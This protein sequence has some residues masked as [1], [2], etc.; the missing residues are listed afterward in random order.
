MTTLTLQPPEWQT[1]QAALQREW[2]VTN[3]LGGWASGTVGGA[4]TR[5]Y[6]GSLVAALHPPVDR[7]VLVSKLDD[8]ATLDCVRYGLC[9]N[10]FEGGA[11]DPQGW[12]HL[13]GFALEDGLPHWTF[14]LGSG[15][16]E[17]R[18]FMPYGHN[19]TW[20][21]WTYTSGTGPLNLEI[22]ALCNAR[23]FHGQTQAANWQLQFQAF[24]AGVCVRVNDSAPSV[25]LVHPGAAFE[26]GPVWIKNLHYQI[27]A[28]R[29]LPD[30]EDVLKI[31][32][33]TASLTPGDTLALLVSA[34]APS[35]QAYNWREALA[36]AQQRQRQV[37]VNS[38]L[39][40]QAPGWVEQLVLAADQFIVLRTDSGL[41][42][43][44]QWRTP[45]P[46]SDQTVIAGYPWFSDWGR[47]TMI[48]LPGLTLATHRAA[49]AAGILRTFAKHL[50]QGMLPN[51]FPDSG[52]T[53]E[54]NTVDATL[55]YFHAID[56]YLEATNDE[57]LPRELFD[58]LE[59]IIA[60]HLKGTRY[61]IHGDTDGLL[62]AGEAGV[63]LTWMDAKVG[64][65]VVTPRIGK[66]VEINALWINALRVMD[67]LS[68]RLALPTRQPYAA[69][70][71]QAQA[72]FGKFWNA[73]D[74]CL[75]DVIDGPTLAQDASIRPNQLL[76]ISLPYAPLDAKSAQAKSVVAVCQRDLLTPVGLRSLAPQSAE[77]TP[78]FRGGP[79][80]RDGAY[81]QGTIW[82][83]LIGPFVEAHFKVYGDK[84]QA[85]DFLKPLEQALRMFGLGT[86]AEVY[87]A[88]PPYNPAGCFAQAW[89][90]SEALRL[91]RALSEGSVAR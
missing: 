41:P 70:A 66:P 4:N 26:A 78:L 88:T 47:D 89:S 39:P 5:R 43:V 82:G 49:E 34:E 19:A 13:S 12:T 25:W 83:W 11:I 50:S 15:T 87:E 72:S 45:D 86:L 27:E 68:R 81:H 28:G 8:W 67:N 62:Y 69:L 14:A 6:H 16:L 38:R 33:V 2:L 51:R 57:A 29:G 42:S 77:Y 35:P 30:H 76:A 36:A 9:A 73:K 84:D 65:W 10:E 48:A 74:G 44:T 85:L 71:D 22:S 24:P 61:Q 20:T 56:R 23:D 18:V 60:W 80:E 40:S 54:Y 46:Q 79:H 17:K 75:F 59:E 7:Q 63:Q 21:L 58:S 37:V 52:E 64:D 1:A 53:P 90:V 55:W 91:W 32:T 3:G 31:G